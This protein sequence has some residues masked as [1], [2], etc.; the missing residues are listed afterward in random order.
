MEMKFSYRVLYLGLFLFQILASILILKNLDIFGIVPIFLLTY[1]LVFPG[2]LLLRLLGIHLSSRFNQVIHSVGLSLSI[3]MFGGL[4]LNMLLPLIGIQKPLTQLNIILFL[5]IF[6]FIIGFISYSKEGKKIFYFHIGNVDIKNILFSIIPVLFIIQ[7]LAG[8]QTLN[9]GGSSLISIALLIEIIFYCLITAL[10]GDRLNKKIIHPLSLFSI[11]ASIL[12]MLSMRSYHVAGFDINQELYVF[13]LTKRLAVWSMSN[14]QNAYNSCLSITILPTMLSFLAKINDEY[15]FKLLYPLIFSLAPVSMY[16]IVKN[17]AKEYIAFLSVLIFIFQPSFILEIAML[18][19]QEIGLFFLVLLLFVFFLN[20]LSNGK[21]IFLFI[22]YY[23]SLV[24]SHYSTTYITLLLFLMLFV[25]TIMRRI[26]KTPFLKVLKI[27]KIKAYKTNNIKTNTLLSWKLITMMLIFTFL[28]NSTLTNNTKGLVYVFRNTLNN[29]SK[30]FSNDLK[31]SSVLAAI[32]NR[33][34]Q[35]TAQDVVNYSTETTNK[36]RSSK[37]Y[38]NKYDQDKYSSYTAKPFYSKITPYNKYIDDSI[39]YIYPLISVF[40]KI[41]MA[42]GFIYLLLHKS[43]KKIV[44]IEYKFLCLI[45]LMLIALFMVL[46]FIS[47]S[48]NF[49]RVIQQTL[50]LLALPVI[51]GL[52]FF[53]RMLFIQ[54]EKLIFFL[55]LLIILIY[56]IFPSGLFNQFVGGFAYLQ[57]NNFGEYYDLY[58]F[59]NSEKSSLQWLS[60]NHDKNSYIYADEYAKLRFLPYSSIT[61]N[62]ITDILPSVID[63]NAYVYSDYSNTI[64]SLVIAKD[65]NSKEISY[66]FPS[67]FL[68]KNKNKIYSNGY[69]ELFK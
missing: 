5:N 61:Q 7:A 34:E 12:L 58:Y 11:S 13:Q 26:L 53:F 49:E 41:S 19:R 48:Y 54:K 55:S 22:I 14:Y 51:L 59:H 17:F 37:L 60:Y 35:F 66:N 46:P 9:N 20:K 63:K 1:F 64:N 23:F 2:F 56:F 6:V 45:S 36:Y 40:L 65:K 16:Y 27:G 4:F 31:S 62:I 39:F 38:I 29:M 44:T 69:S 8:A 50:T 21:K 24:V 30:V 32:W 28:W 15:I 42:V 52:Y 43:G 10:L 25:I 68:N 33:Q 18:A 47:L 3:F 67:D 57:F